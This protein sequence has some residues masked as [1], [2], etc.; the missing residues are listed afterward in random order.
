MA[1]ERTG[2]CPST[3]CARC[4]GADGSTVVA[5]Y[6]HWWNCLIFLLGQIAAI[7]VVPD[8][9]PQRPLGGAFR[10]RIW[11]RQRSLL[12]PQPDA[13][14]PL[15]QPSR[16]TIKHQAVL[17]LC[18]V[19]HLQNQASLPGIKNNTNLQAG[20]CLS[21]TQYRCCCFYCPTMP[22]KI[23]GKARAGPRHRTVLLPMLPCSASS[24]LPCLGLRVCVSHEISETHAAGSSQS[25]SWAGCVSHSASV[26][27]FP[28]RGVQQREV[29]V[30]MA[31]S[32]DSR[33]RSNSELSSS[34]IGHP[35]NKARHECQR[36][37]SRCGR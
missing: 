24:G 31:W 22:P 26:R 33:R 3:G 36:L 35:V 5:D 17:A 15:R 19:M 12:G 13:I 4:L 14:G 23:W 21:G 9:A 11:V 8:E 20:A 30:R 16:P 29:K 2:P 25:A 18:R 27:P 1:C 6:Y 34:P 7:A 32:V 10:H 37:R 28:M